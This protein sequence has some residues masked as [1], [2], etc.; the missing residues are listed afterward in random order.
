ML[1]LNAVV[2]S[3]DKMLRRLLG[4]DIELVTALAPDLGPV[5]ADPGQLEQVLLNLAVNARDAM[6]R[7]GRLT[8]ETANITLTD[9][10]AER[11]HRL[12]PGPYVRL[13]V[14]D[15]GVGMDA[16]TQAHLFEPFFTTKEV[17]RGTGLG[18]ATV[19]GIVK[20]S[21][22]YIWVYSE[23]A[24]GTTVKVYLPRV[25]GAAQPLPPAPAPSRV[26]RG[27][28]TVLLVEDAP[29]RP[30]AR[31]EGARG[32][33]VHGAGRSGWPDRARTRSAASRRNCRPGHGRRHAGDERP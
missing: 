2:A 28:E 14:S 1:D 7:G 30:G 32:L 20:Q 8:V 26:Q 25:T 19:Y 13:A 11:H 17:G 33:W 29:P 9:A 12:P 4:E 31:E 3:M 10:Y 6:P 22:G 24:Q 27:S 15:S 5:S 23:P 18:L 16:A 21:G